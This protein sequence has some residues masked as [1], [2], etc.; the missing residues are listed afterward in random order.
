[1]RTLQE[2]IDQIGPRPS[3]LMER[4]EHTLRVYEDTSD[5]ERLVT[6]TH[7]VYDRDVWTGLT[8]GDLR[9]LAFA[10]QGQENR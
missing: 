6:A 1:M 3:N 7:N 2:T 4:L 9:D 10:L 5:N 8:W